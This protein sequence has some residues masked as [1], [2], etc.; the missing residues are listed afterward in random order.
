MS[1]TVVSTAAE[2]AEAV[3]VGAEVIEVNGTITGS[4]M[5]TL[6][7]GVTLRGGTL[8]FGAKGVRLTKDNVLEDVT[9]TTADTEVAILNDTTV[10]DFGRLT[11]REVTTRGQVL[12]LAE[13]Q[14]RAGHVQVEG[15]R[16]LSA[17]VRGRSRRPHG[18]GVEALQGGFTLW[19]RQPD[20]AVTIT[21]ELLDISIGTKDEPVRG[22]GV[23]VGGHGDW[24]GHGNGGVLAV[25]HLRTGEV[26]TNGGIPAGTPDLISGGVFVI[27]GAR[28]RQVST[29][30]PVSTYGQNDMVLD[31]WG[32]VT[33]WTTTAPVTSHGPSGIGFV[34]FGDIDLLD[35][36]API[37]THG[38][39]ARGFNLYDGSL[40]EARFVGIE[41]HGDGSVGIQISKPMG[42]LLVDGDVITRG[43]EGL[44]LVK[45][46]Q[47]P[48][49]AIALSIK[50]GGQ[51]D[52]IDVT[53]T[54]ATSG[55]A[56]IT[57]EIDGQVGDLAVAGGIHATGHGSDAVHTSL[58]DPDLSDLQITAEDG[59]QVR[60][61]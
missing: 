31:N 54:L 46:I 22:S 38:N 44:S 45:G 61:S 29:T 55:D 15:L 7:P 59:H 39:G 24:Q 49:K 5:I 30:G 56:V 41:T 10:T 28:V 48:L 53:G 37:R 1:S 26:H 43:G 3:N 58:T 13:E 8:E 19:N 35:V 42:T 16:V 14:V 32:T 11:L 2:L 17:D 21:A 12:L 6:Q 20:P 57:A 51:V 52:R 23:F 27:S 60:R 4:P 33:T 34:N 50:P 18:F 47:M 36:R 25:S 40:R 9:L